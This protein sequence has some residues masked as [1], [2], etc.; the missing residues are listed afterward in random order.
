MVYGYKNILVTGGAGCIGMQVCTELINRGFSV[1]LFD[2]PEQ[3]KRVEKYIL[4]EIKI[5]YGSVLDCSSLRDAMIGCDAIIHLAAYLGVR[6]TE[7]N[8]LRCIEINVDGTKNILECAVQHRV[9]KIVFASSSEVYGEPAENPVTEKSTTQGKTVYAV[10]KLTGEELCKAFSQRYPELSY[11]IL[12]YFNTFGPFQIAQF[13]IAK[14]IRNILEDKPPIIYGKGNQIRSYCYVSDTAWATVEA[15]LNEKTNNEIFNI[16]NSKS[17]INLIDL[18]YLVIRLCGKDG[19]IEPRFQPQFK[20]TDRLQER[21][22]FQ[23]FCD[24]TKAR[25]ILGYEP[26]VSI[27]DGISNVL[28]FGTI[29]PKWESTDFDYTIDEWV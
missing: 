20:N 24:T 3:I 25:L 23:R 17:L 7:T 2:L 18:A 11:T 21:E 9:K 6:R 26:K 16:G 10:S 13:V 5:Y 22:V 27:E 8:R 4:P 12:R 14:F 1:H 19:K 29:Y 15:L 28:K